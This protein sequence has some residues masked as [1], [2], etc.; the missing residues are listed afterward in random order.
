MGTLDALDNATGKTT[1]VMPDYPAISSQGD[2][3]DL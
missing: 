3:D 1:L 2:G